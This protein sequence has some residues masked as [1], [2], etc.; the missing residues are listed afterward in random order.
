MGVTTVP[1]S[2]VG[3]CVAWRERERGR[4]GGREWVRE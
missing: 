3:D 2:P 4:K 1:V